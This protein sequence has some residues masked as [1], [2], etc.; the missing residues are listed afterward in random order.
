MTEEEKK[1]VFS[2]RFP[3]D[4]HKLL[5]HIAVDKGVS[6]GDMIIQTMAEW[7]VAQPEATLYAKPATP[8]ASKPGPKAAK[9][10]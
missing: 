1:K 8:K 9:K 10:K 4:L 7:A 6:L 3:H 2:V 5:T